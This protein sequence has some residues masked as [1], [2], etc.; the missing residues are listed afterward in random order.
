MTAPFDTLALAKALELTPLGKDGAE[1]LARAMADVA[2]ADLAT[3]SDLEKA[4][5]Q[6]TVRGFSALVALAGLLVGAFALFR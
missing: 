4:V 2:M 5:H 3:K 6:L 1:A